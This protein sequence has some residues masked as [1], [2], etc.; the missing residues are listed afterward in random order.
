MSCSLYW[1]PPVGGKSAGNFQVRDAIREEFGS[2]PL[3]LGSE[4]LPFLRG[5]KAAKIEDAHILIEAIEK[6]GAV[7]VWTEC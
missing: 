5:L 1:R 3:T 6:H 2:Y 7:E 4:A